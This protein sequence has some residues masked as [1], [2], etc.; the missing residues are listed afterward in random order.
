MFPIFSRRVGVS[1]FCKP[2]HSDSCYVLYTFK[3]TKTKQGCVIVLSTKQMKV[4]GQQSAACV[5]VFMRDGEEGRGGVY[6]FL[7]GSV[8]DPPR[9]DRDNL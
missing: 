4:E 3:K 2:S 9:E 7:Q 6:L 8:G 1:V 5:A